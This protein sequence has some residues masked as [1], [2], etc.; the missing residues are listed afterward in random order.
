MGGKERTAVPPIEAGCTQRAAAQRRTRRSRVAARRG[1]TTG[2]D[3][4]PPL[5]GPQTAP[6]RNARR[7]QTLRA[8]ARLQRS[9]IK[10]HSRIRTAVAAACA[11]SCAPAAAAPSGRIECAT[12]QSKGAADPGGFAEVRQRTL[13]QSR[14]QFPGNAGASAIATR[15]GRDAA[16]DSAARMRRRARPRDSAGRQDAIGQRSA[17]ARAGIP[18]RQFEPTTL[19]LRIPDSARVILEPHLKCA[20]H[21][22]TYRPNSPSSSGAQSHRPEPLNALPEDQPGNFSQADRDQRTLRWLAGV[23]CPRVA[24]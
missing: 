14:V 20:N 10:T 6:T 23:R 19:A 7:P 9:P 11:R 21:D 12:R 17:Y 8:S 13:I 18:I 22:R 15:M 4:P 5:P 1:G 2:S 16:S 3:R 24:E